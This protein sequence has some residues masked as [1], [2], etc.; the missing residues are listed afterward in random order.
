MPG[1]SDNGIRLCEPEQ[2]YYFK[3]LKQHAIA[4]PW[5]SDCPSSAMES[6]VRLALIPETVK[7]D[8]I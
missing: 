8:T 2:S 1:L 4:L 3:A 6:I 7:P 5:K